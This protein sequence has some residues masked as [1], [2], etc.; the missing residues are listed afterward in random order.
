MGELITVRVLPPERPEFRTATEPRYVWTIDEVLA[1]IE[2]PFHDLLSLAHACHR[3]RFDPREI[4]GAKLTS[5][6][7]GA[8]PEDCAY[9]PQS[10]RNETGL[11]PESLLDLP[12]ILA[13]A[14]QAIDEGATRFCMGAA[15]RSPYDR[16]VDEAGEAIHAVADL[17]TETCGA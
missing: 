1:V 8:C 6:K 13:K 16:Q 10:A 9:C 17:G 2:R 7:T 4:E 11:Q 12:N 5:I 15:W 14:E 3:E